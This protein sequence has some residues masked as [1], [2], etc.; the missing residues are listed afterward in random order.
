MLHTIA[1]DDGDDMCE[2]GNVGG[3]HPDLQR[4]GRTGGEQSWQ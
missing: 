4:Q 2:H 3:R 1:P